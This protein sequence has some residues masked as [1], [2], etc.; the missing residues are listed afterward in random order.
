MMKDNKKDLWNALKSAL[1]IS[2]GLFIYIPSWSASW[3]WD[4]YIEIVSN[5]EIRGSLDSL[6]SIWTNPQALDYFPLKSTL[7]WF[8]WHLWG[9]N[10]LGYHLV[11]VVLHIISG[12]LIWRILHKIGMSR[13]WLGGLLFIVHPIAVESVAWI[14]ELKNTLSLPLVRL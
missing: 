14:S 10:P 12:F 5:N 1:L 6:L 3:V 4:D 9:L 13:A 2:L 11:S 8:E 7:Q